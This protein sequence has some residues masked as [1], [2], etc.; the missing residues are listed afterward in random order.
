[1]WNSQGSVNPNN[2]LTL[3]IVPERDECGTQQVVRV[4][5]EGPNAHALMSALGGERTLLLPRRSIPE[6]TTGPL[7]LPN[8]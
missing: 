4:G 3:L 1:M 6:I 7:S 5:C 8:V 2:G